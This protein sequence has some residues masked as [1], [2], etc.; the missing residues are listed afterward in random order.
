M[1]TNAVAVAIFWK[2]L[3]LIKNVRIL[4]VWNSFP[5]PKTK[6]KLVVMYVMKANTKKAEESMPENEQEVGHF[7]LK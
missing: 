1:S 4:R 7:G 3:I 2:P 5:C 6:R